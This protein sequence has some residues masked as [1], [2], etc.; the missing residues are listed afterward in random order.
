MR[1][2][3]IR[4]T[5]A[6][7]TG[8]HIT[9]NKNVDQTSSTMQFTR[10]ALLSFG[11]M[12]GQGAANSFEDDTLFV[13]WRNDHD[14]ENSPEESWCFPE[15]ILRNY[16]PK[17]QF[18]YEAHHSGG[19]QVNFEHLE[20]LKFYINS[21]TQ[22][23]FHSAL[24]GMSPPRQRWNTQPLLQQPNAVDWS[25]AN[26]LKSSAISSLLFLHCHSVDRGSPY[27]MCWTS[28]RSSN[29][30]LSL[31]MGRILNAIF[32]HDIMTGCRNIKCV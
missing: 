9:E 6:A 21:R 14:A 11:H 12:V 10:C 5:F 3:D 28:R 7:S 1:D 16:E 29:Q 30:T 18:N 32:S 8:R 25:S 31:R 15:D 23:F 13:V 19:L 20:I 17:P 22:T 2:I 27:A 24:I 26:C 4:K